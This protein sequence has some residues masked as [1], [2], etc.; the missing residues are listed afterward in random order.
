MHILKKIKHLIYITLFLFFTFSYLY[1]LNN[2]TNNHK[3]RIII[4]EKELTTL[5]KKILKIAKEASTQ[6]S[7][8]LEKAIDTNI[9]SDE[10]IFSTLYFPVS[11]LT[12]P[13]KF[14]TFYDDYTDKF[15]TPLE[16]MFAKKNSYIIF[17]ALVDKNGYLPS[18][19][20]KFSQ[21][22]ETTELNIKYNRTKRIFNDTTGF[23]AAKNTKPFL[24]QSYS[25]DT[26]ETFTDL[27]TPVFVKGKHWG[28]V[29][30]GYKRK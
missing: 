14:T 29:R 4:N 6:F 15:I 7:K 13:P 22:K 9:K 2:N 16:D 26:G 21:K 30:I 11:P 18:H 5:D 19:N 24:L 12:S 10:E 17:I 20:T 23:L 28:A 8:I 27:S 1:S 25:R 3:V